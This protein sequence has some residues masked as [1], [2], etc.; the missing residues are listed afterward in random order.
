MAKCKNNFSKEEIAILVEDVEA[1]S[2]LLFSKLNNVTTNQQ[3]TAVWQRI[4]EKINAV[5]HGQER[6][7]ADIRQKWKD[8]ASHTK[9]KE[10]TRRREEK[11]TGGDPTKSS[12]QLS[13]EKEKIIHII[14]ETTVSGISGGVD[15]GLVSVDNIDDCGMMLMMLMK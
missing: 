10:C 2:G 9:K 8:L 3:K 6:S 13:N 11:K 7:S 15:T 14:G 1:N 4:T 5:N 12:Q